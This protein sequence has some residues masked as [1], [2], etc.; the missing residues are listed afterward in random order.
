MNGLKHPFTGAL[1]E[2]DGENRV[3]VS[4]DGKTGL[5]RGDGFWLEGDIREADPHF[6]G[7]ISGPIFGNHR[8]TPTVQ[9][10]AKSNA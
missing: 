7:W 9:D 6:C 5:F 1:Y 4:L 10:A 2:Q 3:R 8:V